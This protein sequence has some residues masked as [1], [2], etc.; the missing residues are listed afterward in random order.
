MELPEQIVDSVREG[1]VILFLGAMASAPSPAAS[2]F[3]YADGPP[4]GG[5]I[6]RRLAKRF[7]YPGDDPGNLQRVALYVEFRQGGSRKEL[8]DAVGREIARP[9][10]DSPQGLEIE[11]SPALRMLAALPFRIVI[12]T[13]YDT[14]FD[15]ALGDAVDRNGAR[16]RPI[17]RVYD[18]RRGGPPEEVPVDPEEQR[19]VL[20]KLHGDI[21]RP[22]SVVITEE[23]YIA[24]VQNMGNPHLHPVHEYIRMRM[25]AWPFLFV[26]YSLRD[27]NLRLLFRTLRW[28]LD[29]SQ[30][31]LS[32]S[33]DPA[34]DNL[35]VAVWQRATQPMVSFVEQ[36]LWQF[37][38]ALH[39]AVLGRDYAP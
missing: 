6:S 14:L 1:K 23:D 13:N 7:G 34:P 27:Y 33:V 39:R 8:I 15:T 9:R 24:F 2:P 11:P 21:D 32:F 4:S 22:E 18:P 19:P 37:V 30:F 36:D 20:L 16:K 3:R 12:T 10:E 29:V 28:G 38:P 5:E 25:R 31:P 17:K 26:G 35:V